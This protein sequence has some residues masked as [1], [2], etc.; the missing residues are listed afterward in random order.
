MPGNK[1][2]KDIQLRTQHNMQSAFVPASGSIWI[3]PL[4]LFAAVMRGPPGNQKELRQTAH[5]PPRAGVAPK[6]HDR[7]STPGEP[8]LYPGFNGCAFCRSTT[9]ESLPIMR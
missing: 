9:I 3:C 2:H 5:P 1:L 7:S 6:Q 4:A 8:E